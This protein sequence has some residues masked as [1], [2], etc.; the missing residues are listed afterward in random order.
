MATRSRVSESNLSHPDA[1]S[2]PLHHR[3]Q[4]P[5]RTSRI[6]EKLE[7]QGLNDRLAGYIDRVRFLE[8]ENNRLTVEVKTVRET[9]TREST[10]I[11]SVCVEGRVDRN[12]ECQF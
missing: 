2:T 11:K 12:L 6:T 9:V 1:A 7:L 5:T 3:T 10:N 8:A 4:S